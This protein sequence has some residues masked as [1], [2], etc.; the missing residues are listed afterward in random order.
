MKQTFALAGGMLLAFSLG[1]LSSSAQSEAEPAFDK[2]KSLV[3]EWEGVGEDGIH[4]EVRYE[5]ISGGTALWETLAPENEPDMVTVYTLDGDHLALTHYCSANNQPHMTTEPLAVAPD[6]L[7]FN[8]AG[9]T[10]LPSPDGYM[11][12]LVLTLEDPDHLTQTWTWKQTGND[13]V[14]VF[15]FT[16]KK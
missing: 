1:T 15:R 9:G 13:H 5:L 2:L 12:G 3:G 10:N 8:F 16:R 6:K 7:V 14:S 4:R 11:V